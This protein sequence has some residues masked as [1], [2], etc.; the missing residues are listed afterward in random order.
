[1]LVNKAV[2][3]EDDGFGEQTQEYIPQPAEKITSAHPA[4][5]LEPQELPYFRQATGKI[6]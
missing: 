1:V 3:T 2:Y 4:G 5:I 6:W